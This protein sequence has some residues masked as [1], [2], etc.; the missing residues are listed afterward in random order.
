MDVAVRTVTLHS[1]SLS[2][3]DSGGDDSALLFI[4]GLL[5]SRR[6]WRHLVERLDP[7]HR[8][9][10]PDSIAQNG[11]S[12]GRRLHSAADRVELGAR[13]NR[14]GGAGAPTRGL[15]AQPEAG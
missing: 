12:A 4:H 3:L 6:S 1:W 7:Q 8:V 15:A 11:H 10:A 5:G 2:Y 9:L 14:W 13:F